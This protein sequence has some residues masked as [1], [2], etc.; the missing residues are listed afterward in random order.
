MSIK[1][2]VETLEAE[3]RQK[4]RGQ[5]CEF[6]ADWPSNRI[7]SDEPLKT[8]NR[9]TLVGNNVPASCPRCGFTPTLIKIKLVTDWRGG[10]AEHTHE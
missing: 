3:H 9:Q 1:R 10:R 6:C 5:R 7:Y 8:S 4:R 2:K